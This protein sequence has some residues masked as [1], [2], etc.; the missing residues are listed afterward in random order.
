MLQSEASCTQWGPKGGD[1]QKERAPLEI[2]LRLLDDQGETSIASYDFVSQRLL[3]Q[4]VQTW[5]KTTKRIGAYLLCS[6]WL[7]VA[8]ETI[9]N[10]HE[11]RAATP[12]LGLYEIRMSSDTNRELRGAFRQVLLQVSGWESLPSTS[13]FKEALITP[14]DYL[15]GK[16]NEIG[17]QGQEVVFV[18]NRTQVDKL[19]HQGG[20]RPNRETHLVAL[21]WFVFETDGIYS[22]I[23][24]HNAPEMAD[25]L[26]SAANK[27]DVSLI[28]PPLDDQIRRQSI[29]K[30]WSGDMSELISTAENYQSDITS[31]VDAFLLA[32]AT[33]SEGKGWEVHWTL[34]Q[35]GQESTWRNSGKPLTIALTNGIHAT[36][37]RL[38]TSNTMA[39]TTDEAS[40]KLSPLSKAIVSPIPGSSVSTSSASLPELP[41]AGIPGSFDIEISGIDLFTDYVRVENYLF[42]LP[43]VKSVRLRYLHS[44]V[45]VLSLNAQGGLSALIN[46]IVSEKTLL[47]KSIQVDNRFLF[48]H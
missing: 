16:R 13:L 17:P 6:L 32:R 35:E 25:A 21:A 27:Q 34:N 43:M 36:A 3:T 42:S 28:L 11:V 23:N 26:I 2:I 31:S 5:M 41:P 45:I 44:S 39:S 14:D 47:S 4:K 9:G 29:V 8:E 20:L 37:T 1:P 38:N 33:R 7:F 22:F 40:P 19:L 24:P 30:V 15:M 18:F 12:S 10:R 48:L 46:A